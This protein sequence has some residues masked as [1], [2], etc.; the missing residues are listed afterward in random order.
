MSLVK[1]DITKAISYKAQIS[2]SESNDV[3]ESF[4]NIIKS[5]NTKKVN[6]SNF[7]VFSR[8]IT[9]ERLGRNPKNKNTYIIPKRNKLSFKL[10]NKQRKL[11]N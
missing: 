1:K 5:C 7:G 11:L 9:P 6:I 4:L 10:S 2:L 3:F 8:N